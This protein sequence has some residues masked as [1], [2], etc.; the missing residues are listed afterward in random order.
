[1]DI[2]DEVY[3]A[4]RDEWRAWLEKNHTVKNGV[5]LVYYKKGSGKP[6]ILYDDA[7]EEAL[8]WGWID[9]TVKTIDEGKYAQLFTPRKK[10][11]RWSELNIGRASKMIGQGKMANAGL[12]KYN[13]RLEYDAEKQLERLNR[14]LAMPADLLKTLESDHAALENFNRFSPSYGRLCIRWINDVKKED[15]PQRRIARVFD[16]SKNNTKLWGKNK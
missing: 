4:T 7:V 3:L 14:S 6:R 2:I 1:M 12:L 5:W 9:T 13:D 11:S 16:S 15:A 8:C 10:N